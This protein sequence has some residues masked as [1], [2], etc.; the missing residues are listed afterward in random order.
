MGRNSGGFT[1]WIRNSLATTTTQRKINSADI[2]GLLLH[3]NSGQD[4]IIFNLYNRS[5]SRSQISPTI[6]SLS[7]ELDL[8][9]ENFTNSPTV[10]VAGACDFNC[11]Y[12][13]L[14]GLSHLLNEE[15]AALGIPSL[16][17]DLVVKTS[18]L[19]TQILALTAQY[20]LR[21]CNGRSPSD[22]MRA[23][24]FHRN[25]YSSTLDYIL[26]NTDSCD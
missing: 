17:K 4:M 2:L 12:E 6:Q 13:P 9:G 16:A 8:I 23:P 10:I 24:T 20:S 3:F 21:A 26:I 7:L 1:I 14:E 18:I 22:P 25:Q 5:A 15:D 19:A 11:P